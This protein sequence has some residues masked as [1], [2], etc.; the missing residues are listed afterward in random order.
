MTRNRALPVQ[1]RILPL[2]TWISRLEISNLAHDFN[3]FARASSNPTAQN[4][5]LL[6][7]L[8]SGRAEVVIGH[9]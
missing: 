4:F 6:Y 2:K 1:V 7:F 8:I 5:D 3:F 9:D